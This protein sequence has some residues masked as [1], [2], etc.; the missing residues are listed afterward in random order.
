MDPFLESC[1]QID[2]PHFPSI[3][4][5][6]MGS[7]IRSVEKPKITTISVACIFLSDVKLYRGATTENGRHFN[8]EPIKNRS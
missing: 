3:K 8:E 4:T 1:A 2:G 7:R 5:E 6:D